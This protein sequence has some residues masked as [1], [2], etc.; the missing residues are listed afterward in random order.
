MSAVCERKL[1][2]GAGA[3]DV[4]RDAWHLSHLLLTWWSKGARRDFL[5]PPRSRADF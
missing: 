4:F 3:E 1:R 2:A 5:V